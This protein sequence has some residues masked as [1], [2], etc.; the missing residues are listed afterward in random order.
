GDDIHLVDLLAEVWI[1]QQLMINAV[2]R[3]E[4]CLQV[5]YA[6]LQSDGAGEAEAIASIA[7]PEV[8]TSGKIAPRHAGRVIAVFESRIEKHGLV[9]A[10]VAAILLDHVVVGSAVSS[11]STLH[12][13]S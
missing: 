1:G 13:S 8:G 2:G 4:D 9:E 7:L 3:S 6:R 12:G 5:V 10:Q 11:G